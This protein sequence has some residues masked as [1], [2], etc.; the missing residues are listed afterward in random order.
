MPFEMLRQPLHFMP[1]PEDAPV[2][3]KEANEKIKSADGF[4]IISAEYNCGIPP[5]LSNMMNHFPPAS[6]RHRP[7]GIV[8]YSMGIY[9]GVRAG[10]FIRPFASE[11]GIVTIPSYVGI[12]QV[13]ESF[14]EDGTSKTERVT[15]NIKKLVNEVGWYASALGSYKTE[16]PPPS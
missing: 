11:L 10:A 12:P 13:Q 2:W 15:N 6:Y 16:N 1:N 7:C 4:I 14:G 5:A 8:T 9:G 3:M